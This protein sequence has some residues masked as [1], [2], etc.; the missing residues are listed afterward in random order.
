M[1]HAVRLFIAPISANAMYTG[2]RWKSPRAKQFERDIAILLAMK[3]KDIK[4]P[5][6]EL[7]IHWRFGISR[8][9]D[10]SNAVKLAEDEICKFL[11]ID[12]R[13]FSGMTLVRVPVKRGKEFISFQ[14][15]SY[16]ESDFPD[17]IVEEKKGAV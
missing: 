3:A 7:T 6:G 4:V 17:L 5:D 16:Q 11:G 12:D 15:L 2:R 1:E 9:F 10:V 8:R 14:I 13:R